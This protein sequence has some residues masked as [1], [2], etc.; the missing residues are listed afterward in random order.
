[1][2][3]T[4]PLPPPSDCIPQRFEEFDSESMFRLHSPS[5]DILLEMVWNMGGGEGCCGWSC[6]NYDVEWIQQS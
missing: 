5:G 2:A 3:G 6:G 4:P 1:M